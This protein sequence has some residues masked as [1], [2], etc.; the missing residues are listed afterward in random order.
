MT[1]S[2]AQNPATIWRNLHCKRWDAVR[3]C[4]AHHAAQIP[5]SIVAFE[6]VTFEQ[7]IGGEI[8]PNN[9]EEV[10]GQCTTPPPPPPHLYCINTT[11]W[12]WA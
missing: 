6:I 11:V 12:L 4:H 7:V 2:R 1:S 5:D 10:L 8:L 9:L 3:I